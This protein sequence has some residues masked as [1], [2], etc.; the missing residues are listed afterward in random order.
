MKGRA[1]WI[2]MT[3]LLA[4][5]AQSQ[6]LATTASGKQITVFPDGT[7]KAVT[8][9]SASAASRPAGASATLPVNRGRSAV[10]YNPGKWKLQNEEQGGRSKLEHIEGDG[11][12]MVI[13]ERVG[14]S[15]D[16]LKNIALQ[17]AKAAAP[18]AVIVAEEP[19]KVNGADLLMLQIEG[20]VSGIPF[21]YFGYYYTGEYGSI[22]VIT[23]TGRNLFTE[24][25]PDFEELL[26]GF[27]VKP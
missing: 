9:S 2:L 6:E 8:S 19:R 16:V 20:T 27:V 4:I 3:C 7:W 17:N 26:N 25:K 24:F 11:Y 15:I 5:S 13:A 10:Y 14:M 23:F 1:A 22:Q 21:T 18:D 12:A